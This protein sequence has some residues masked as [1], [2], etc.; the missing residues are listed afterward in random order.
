M[1]QLN[2][3]VPDHRGLLISSFLTAVPTDKVITNAPWRRS[4]LED[5][6]TFANGKG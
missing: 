6:V 1:S 3:P 2:G 5:A 4:S